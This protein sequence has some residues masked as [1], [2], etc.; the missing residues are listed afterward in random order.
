MSKLLSLIVKGADPRP[1]H[2]AKVLGVNK[3]EVERE[4]SEL[5]D[6]RRSWGGFQSLIPKS[7]NPKGSSCD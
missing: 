1:E 6:P 5:H 7:P 3:D 2:L 4:L